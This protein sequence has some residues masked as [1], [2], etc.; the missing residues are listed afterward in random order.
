GLGG[1]LRAVPELLQN[2]VTPE[3]LASAMREVL[4]EPQWTQTRDILARTRSILSG[5][6]L[7]VENAARAVTE[8]LEARR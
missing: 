7:P 2:D 5:E 4:R 6:G 3:K 8:F 1:E